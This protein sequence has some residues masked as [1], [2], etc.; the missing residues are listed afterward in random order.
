MK[1]TL[2]YSII[3]LLILA[4][5]GCTRQAK[6]A[7]PEDL[8]KEIATHVEKTGESEVITKVFTRQEYGRT[9]VKIIQIKQGKTTTHEEEF[10]TDSFLISFHVGTHIESAQE[11]DKT[12][13]A[14]SGTDT[15]LTLFTQ[16]LQVAR[17]A[18]GRN[19]YVVAL[20]SLNSALQLDNDNPQAK[21]MKGS[22]FYAM[23]KYEMA[24]KEFDDILRIDPDNIEVKQF[25][26]FMESESGETDKAKDEETETQ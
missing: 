9:Y 5:G 23:G 26:E 25:N 4:I 10:D 12:T 15:N 21:M 20:E 11:G 1:Q 16:K 6:E 3:G 24:K 18:M 13:L 19:D 2:L 7:K 17:D 8:S 22:V 14:T